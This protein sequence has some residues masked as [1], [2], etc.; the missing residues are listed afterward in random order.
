MKL[1]HLLNYLP[2]C[3][4]STLQSHYYGNGQKGDFIY[5]THFLQ[6]FH[7]QKTWKSLH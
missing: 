6:I 3:C 5:N 4:Y 2:G 7:Y 1:L